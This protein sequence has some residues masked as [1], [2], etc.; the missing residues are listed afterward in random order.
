MVLNRST[1]SAVS[2]TRNAAE[3][4]EIMKTVNSFRE[5]Y[6]QKFSFQW[7]KKEDLQEVKIFTLFLKR[8]KISRRDNMDKNKKELL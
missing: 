3:K 5:I 1:Q 8:S 7:Q 4:T 2:S 6:F